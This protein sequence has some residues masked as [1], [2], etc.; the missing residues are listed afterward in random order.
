MVKNVHIFFAYL[1]ILLF[2]GNNN[3]AAQSS[4]I[5]CKGVIIDSETNETLEGIICKGLNKNKK[6][7]LSYTLSDANGKFSIDIGDSQISILS[8]E[9]LGFQTRELQLSEITDSQNVH[10][11]LQKKTHQLKEIS[12]TI[13]PIQRNNDTISYN[14]SQF[15]SQSDQYIVDILKKLPGINVNEN[16]T[17]SYQGEAINKF[18]I[19]G[20]D[21]LGG[22]YNIASNNLSI[23]AV[24]QVQVLENN[25]HIKALKN[26]EFSDKAAINIKLKKGFISKPFGELEAG[27]GGFGST[28]YNGQFFATQ[29][30]TTTQT[31]INSKGN[32][33][34][35]NI[36]SEVEEKLD[37]KNLFAS[38]LLPEDLITLSGLKEIP[39]PLNRY[40][41]NRTYLGGVNNLIVLSKDTELK[42]NLSYGNNHL[43]QN[44]FLQQ[45]FATGNEN[46]EINEQTS[47]AI[48]ADNYIASI[49]LEHNSVTKYFKNTIKSAGKWGK[50][51]MII[52][53][54]NRSLK[55]FN[56]NEPIYIQNDLGGLLKF[57]N[58]QTIN[59]SSFFR[60]V[61]KAE[62][63]NS[64][65]TDTISSKL[66]EKIYGKSWIFKNKVNTTFYL[67]KQRLDI[68]A[69][70]SFQTNRIN[71]NI[72]SQNIRGID[73][74]RYNF[75]PIDNKFADFEVSLLPTYQ[76][77]H[78]KSV[79]TTIN[80]P[81]SYKD[82]QVKT[83]NNKILSDNRVIITPS[84]SNNYNV[85]HLWELRTKV[86]YDWNYANYQ[87]LLSNSYFQSYRAIYLPSDILG[88]RKNIAI[89]AG[90]RYKD[91]VNMMFFN[92]TALY[93]IN[94]LNYM[95]E[96][97]NSENWS[98]YTTIKKNN[99]GKQILLTSNISKT[100]IPIKTA[101]TL[102]PL[103][104]QNTSRLIQQGNLIKNKS[105]NASL[106][107]NVEV[108]AIRN[109][110][111][112]YLAKGKIGW[113]DN[114]L[115]NKV[116]LKDWAQTLSIYYFPKKNIDLSCH[117]DYTISE[118]RKRE[119]ISYFF[120]D[121]M[122]KYKYKQIEFG[123]SAT[124]LLN[125]DTYSITYLSTVNSDYQKFPLRGR[126]FLFSTKFKF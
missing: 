53:S 95:Y 105:N 114:N 98:Y 36:I 83:H 16:G 28:L 78:N 10:I 19:E 52:H 33:V 67:F 76:I 31:I 100:F 89:S 91:I 75:F 38:E 80:I 120:L 8:F 30:G 2:Q 64:D 126:E 59:I 85:N 87:T 106:S 51:A 77:N 63:L 27:I 49:I 5:T 107:L 24:S 71:S 60:Y 99:Y 56:N 25:Q 15:Q 43:N 108:K 72:A 9:C 92:F 29:L 116:Y 14:V 84:I 62:S 70:L 35:K 68:G 21:L 88:I 96:T 122:A 50:N 39:I 123:L 119:Y 12:I 124:N 125:K 17:I 47:Q 34:G 112:T 57:E 110:N 22:Q 94:N 45:L 55:A 73:S 6:T 118:I 90:I 58:D 111:I 23:N 121:I 113:Q 26:V 86:G 48:K 54:D 32:N 117:S 41:Q 82:Y 97:D 74:L 13:P 3:L 66:H 11:Y 104:S 20:R 18:Y 61:D 4:K 1:I 103:F 42:I 69:L 102:S 37:Y 81:I 65:M 7:I 79:I 101:I 109:T 93:S 46:L 115:K 40:L 44:F